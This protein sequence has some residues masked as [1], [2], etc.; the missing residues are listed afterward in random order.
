MFQLCVSICTVVMFDVAF[1]NKKE[2]ER[3]KL[4]NKTVVPCLLRLASRCVV[5]S[6]SFKAISNSLC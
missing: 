5:R 3:E 1:N 4:K 2:R 6:F